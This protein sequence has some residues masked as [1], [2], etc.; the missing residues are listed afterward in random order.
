MLLGRLQ[1]ILDCRASLL[2]LAS[3]FLL[4]SGCFGQAKPQDAAGRFDGPAELPRVT[5]K[6]SMVDTPAPGSVHQVKAGDDLQAAIDGAKCG[7]TLKLEAG[8]TLA[9]KFKFPQKSCDDSHWIIIRSS[10]PDDVLPTE[11]TRL[12]PCYGGVD[13][14]PG[15]PDLKCK[16]TKAVLP[17]IVFDAPG[18]SGP[19]LFA[20]GANHYR[21]IGLEI[22]RA[23]AQVN[24]RDLVASDDPNHGANHLIFDR[25]WL[26]GTATDETKAGVHLNGV[27][28]AAVVDS[29]LNDLHCVA[30]CTD[31]QAI[32]GGGGTLPGGPYK[33]ENNFIE[34]SGENIMFG[35]GPGNTTPTDIEIRHNHFF[36]PMIWL[37]GQPGYVPGYTG[38]PFIVK[39]LFE[40]KNA[41]RV[42]FEGNLLEN[43]WGGF[44][45]TGFGIV[46]TPANQGG[47]CPD[48][49][50][51]DVTLRYNRIRHVG[52]ALMIANVSVRNDPTLVPFAGGHYSVHDLLFEDIGSPELKGFGAFLM[53]VSAKPPVSDVKIDHVTAFPPG[54]VM[55]ILNRFD[56]V[57]N[58]AIT[59]NVLTAGKRQIVGAG[60]GPENCVK[61]RDDNASALANCFDNIDFSHN[62]I[63]GGT[64][65]WPPGN[66]I[67]TDAA[68]AKFLRFAD[69]KGGD[70]RL[71][72]AKGEGCPQTSRGIKAGSDGRD[73]GADL[74]ALEKAIA[75]VD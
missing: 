51:T 42:L 16:S 24:M 27:T 56:K 66:I 39:N 49:R 65:G 68:D 18:G 37:M 40:L 6:S 20:D 43:S 21:F 35:G 22:T 67:V 70:Y 74:D 4:S 25:I 19:I 15:R 29:Y 32:N 12:T 64:K 58:I 73:L 9:G 11:G 23:K 62:L 41:Q 63:I 14:L 71:C 13:A 33:I 34:A 8:A 46:L 69:G 59:N 52:S 50:V 72:K 75:G 55:S 53:F 3:V 2:W 57:K 44:T 54:T 5:V 31:A 28:Y 36:K 38:R 61:G 60:G 1:R 10:A 26:H 48:C 17:K 7:D 45:Q 30:A 47:K